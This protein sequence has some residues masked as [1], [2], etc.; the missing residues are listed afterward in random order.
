MVYLTNRPLKLSF[1]R[2]A[3]VQ[4]DILYEGLDRLQ[5]PP[6][7]T[8]CWDGN[9]ADVRNYLYQRGVNHI[10]G[11]M[12]LNAGDTVYYLAL[13]MQNNPVAVTTVTIN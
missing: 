5:L 10:L 3:T 1:M 2:N 6:E 7:L 11:S 13:N 8:L 4:T 9:S 12:A